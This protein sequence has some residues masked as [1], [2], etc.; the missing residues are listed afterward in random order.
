MSSTWA[1]ASRSRY[2]RI[3][4]AL[5]DA[6]TSRRRS[7]KRGQRSFLTEDQFLDSLLSKRKHRF[8]LN[9]RVW[10][11]FG[12]RLQ[13]DQAAVLG[14]HRVEVGRCLGVFGVVEVE[15]R[16][17]VDDAAADRGQILA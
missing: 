17:A 11:A 2:S 12:R 1:S 15:H 4:P 5:P 14:H 6:M 9:S 8:E 16:G 10:C 3:F 7:A 13:L